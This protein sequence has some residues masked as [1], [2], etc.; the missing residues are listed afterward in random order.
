MCICD[1]INYY[2]CSIWQVYCKLCAKH[3][4]AIKRDSRLRGSALTECNKYIEGTQFITKW[5]V[6]RHF[7]ST[8]HRCAVSEE[9]LLESSNA[10]STSDASGGGSSS[11]SESRVNDFLILIG[12]CCGINWCI[13]QF[14]L[15]L[16]LQIMIDCARLCFCL[17]IF[18]RQ[19]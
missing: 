15:K 5:T 7:E 18:Y 17:G 13:C 14:K 2:S 3:A 9:K 12:I 10:P 6:L 16:N 8:A 4:T 19:L 11:Q 1:L